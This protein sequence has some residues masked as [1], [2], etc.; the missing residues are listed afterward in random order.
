MNH[1][2]EIIQQTVIIVQYRLEGNTDDDKRQDRRQIQDRTVEVLSLQTFLQHNCQKQC[3]NQ[4]DNVGYDGKHQRMADTGQIIFIG[5]KNLYIVFE[6][7]KID[8]SHGAGI[9]VSQR[10]EHTKNTGEQ[11]KYTIQ[12]QR[13]DQKP[14]RIHFLFIH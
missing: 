1:I 11:E 6:S 2:Q 7:H 8:L 12:R 14:V 5:C 4:L 10:I 9:P 13:D 3:R